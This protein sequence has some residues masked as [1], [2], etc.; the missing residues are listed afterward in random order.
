M[1]LSAFHAMNQLTHP[2]L[3][4][5]WLEID[6]DAVRQNIAAFRRMVGPDRSVMPCLKA[7]AY[8]HGAVECAGAV[9]AGGADRIAVATCLEG[10]QLREAGIGVPIQVLGALFPE[11]VKPAVRFGLTVSLHEL[12]IARL[13]ALEAVATGQTIPI[14]LK[15]D[16]GMGRLG[17]LPENAVEAAQEVMSLPGLRF[18]GV[19][20]HFAE[21]S[22]DAYSLWQLK[23]FDIA[24]QRLEKAGITGF[25][26]HAASSS[27]IVSYYDSW[28]DMIRPGLATYG[29]LAPKWLHSEVTLKPAMTWRAAI[30][31]IK[32]YPSGSNLGYNRTFTTRRPTRI[33]VLPLGYADGYLRQYSNRAE[34]LIHGRRAP[35]VGMVS[36]DY[37]MVDV[38][39]FDDLDVGSI[40]TIIGTDAGDSI[41]AEDLA[42]WGETIPYCVTTNV[43]QRL[44]RVYLDFTAQS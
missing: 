10:Q 7:N 8:G 40:V 37:S 24:C 38:T 19:C 44:G 4:R 33:A 41:T 14:H 11:E 12:Y 36:M 34:V 5:S 6:L 31:Q 1:S 2:S 29:C 3:H 27:A 18:E 35:V 25:L 32:D 42:E 23:R 21:A 9:I 15:I 17:I 39:E 20:M 26:R 30:I 16:T 28:F 43:G 22:D 13:V